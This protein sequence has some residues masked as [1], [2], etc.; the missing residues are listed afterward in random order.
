LWTFY[1]MLGWNEGK[2]HIVNLHHS[3]SSTNY[4]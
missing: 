1:L 2:L 3:S 4:A